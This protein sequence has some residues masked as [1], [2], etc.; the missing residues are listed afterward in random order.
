[1]KRTLQDKLLFPA[2]NWVIQLP[3]RQVPL[4][5]AADSPA[6]DATGIQIEDDSQIEPT[7]KCGRVGGR[8]PALSQGRRIEVA[9]MRDPEGRGIAELARLF[10]ISDNTIRRA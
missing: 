3:D 7:L 6:D 9:R 10:Q 1:M 2:I 8:P 5:P 4:H